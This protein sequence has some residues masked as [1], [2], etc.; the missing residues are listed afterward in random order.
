[1]FFQ[2]FPAQ[3]ISLKVTYIGAG[4][5]FCNRDGGELEETIPTVSKFHRSE[6]YHAVSSI[7]SCLCILP[8]WFSVLCQHCVQLYTEDKPSQ[9][10]ERKSKTYDKADQDLTISAVRTFAVSCS[11]RGDVIET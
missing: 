7:F 9:E 8:L 6:F 10:I 1:L 4:W 2:S 3:Q 11:V 5:N